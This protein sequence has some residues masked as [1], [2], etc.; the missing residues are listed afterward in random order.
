MRMTPDMPEMV[1][2]TTWN[3]TSIMDGRYIKTD[4]TGEM[5]GMGPF[6]GMAVIGF[7]NITGKFV[8]TWIDNFGTG[9]MTGVGELS[10]DQKTM[11]C[12]YTHNCPISKKPVQMREV[13][14]R[15]SD[16]QMAVEFFCKDPKSGKEFTCMKMD[17]KRKP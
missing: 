14:R 1:T 10:A 4:V 12:T 3:S 8:S 15:V 7:D 16:N 6:S 13:S 9:I 5:P 2:P 17:L 11:T